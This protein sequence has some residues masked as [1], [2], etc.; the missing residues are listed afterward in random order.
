M[1]H[2]AHC[3]DPHC[4]HPDH[5]HEDHRSHHHHHHHHHHEHDHHHKHDG[6]HCHDHNC[7]HDHDHNENHWLKAGLG[8][9]FGVVMLA[10]SLAGVA[11]PMLWVFVLTG[12][13]AAL[14]LYLGFNIYQS[15]FES[16]GKGQWNHATLYTISSLVLVAVSIAGLFFPGFLIIGETAA[17]ILGFWHLGEAIE[18]SLI[19]KLEEELDIRDCLPKKVKRDNQLVAVEDLEPGDIIEIQPGDVIPVDGVLQTE[20]RLETTRVNGS[21]KL[22]RFQPGDAVKSGMQLPKHSPALRVEVLKPYAESH[23]SIEAS[24]IQ[25]AHKEKAPLE[26]LTSQILKYFTPTILAIAIISGV[27]IGFL[28]TPML[29]IQCAVAVLVSACPCVLSLITPMTVKL[30][31]KKGHDIGVRFKDSKAVQSGAEID[32]VV[33]DQNGT[34][35]EGESRVTGLELPEQDYVRHLALLEQEAEHGIGRAIHTYLHQTYEVNIDGL[36]LEAFDQ[37]NHSGLKARIDGEDFIVGNKDMLASHGIQDFPPPFNNPENGQIYF[38]RNQTIIGQIQLHDK[39]RPDAIP[40]LRALEKQG[41]RIHMA[42]GDYI[43][44]ALAVATKLGIPH[45]QVYAN[46][47]E[48]TRSKVE[49]IKSLQ[50]KGR[51]VAM[52]GDSANDASAIAH[53]DLGIAVKSPTAHAITEH[54]AGIVLQQGELFPIAQTFEIA[55]SAKQTITAN[56]GISLGYNGAITLLAAGLFIALGLTLNPVIGVALMILESTIVMCVLLAF[57]A[58]ELQTKLPDETGQTMRHGFFSQDST[59]EMLVDEGDSLAYSV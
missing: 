17:M 23:L 15:A 59:E 46:S 49:Y 16:L 22:K 50:A 38:V 51:K 10:L 41:K 58:S 11:L 39:I 29:A 19:D 9:S 42:T 47:S 27:V 32:D 21:S 34:L 24:N 35:T 2:H 37:S 26:V 20:A 12:I 33:F 48:G 57:K 56:L 44:T 13:G 31:M 1:V 3:T 14:T 6:H 36:T 4:D 53:A 43:E 5:H 25:R 18:H 28:F 52:V 45:S 7:G 54:Q 40:M 8:L 55:S 30:A